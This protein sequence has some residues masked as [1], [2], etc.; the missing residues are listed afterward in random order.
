MPLCHYGPGKTKLDILAIGCG[1][2]TDM[3][4]TWTNFFSKNVDTFI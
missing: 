4:K 2:N 3:V 1:V